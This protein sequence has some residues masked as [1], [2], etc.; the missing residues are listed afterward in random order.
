MRTLVDGQDVDLE[1]EPIVERIAIDL[2]PPSMDDVRADDERL[3]HALERA[4]PGACERVAVD[5]ARALSPLLRDGDGE[6]DAFVR[7]GELIA[8]GPPGRAALGLAV[9]LGTTNISARLASL[10][11]GETLASAGVEN[12]QT[13]YGGDL[14]SY[15]A[16]VRHAED[17]AEELQAL[18][19]EALGALVAELCVH[20]GASAEQILDAVVVGNTMMQHLLLGLPVEP[21]ATAPFV[22]ALRSASE[23]KA[24]DLGLDLAPAARVYLPPNIAAFVGGDHVS[25]LLATGCARDARLTLAMDIGTNTEISLLDGDSIT[26]VSCPSGPAFEGAHIECGMRAA[27]GAIERVRLV[28]NDVRVETIEDAPAAGICG[29]GVLDTVAQL[30]LAG[31]VDERGRIREGHP[32]VRSRGKRREFVLVHASDAAGS[33]LVFTQEDVRAVQ[34]AKAAIRSATDLLLEATGHVEGELEQ[35]IVAGAFGNYIDVTSAQAIGL[36]PPLPFRRFA[37]VGNAAG[38]GARLALL[39]QRQRDAAET[40]ADRCRYVELAGH[41]S[42]QS[43]YLGRIG[44]APLR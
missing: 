23:L 41:P 20:A 1:L 24:R 7:R 8:A 17:G 11:S 36:L 14:I 12:P 15:A 35:V 4:R 21:L 40:I 38:D 42:F 43:T 25:M 33:E 39:S 44:F 5:A 18:A 13:R 22:P 34:L 16:H 26:S 3:L 28:G 6:L 27:V 10:E 29:S 37:Q 9:D 30:Y 32:R 31:V 19:V 2:P